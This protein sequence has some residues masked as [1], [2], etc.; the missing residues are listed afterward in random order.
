MAS[1]LYGP[2]NPKTLIPPIIPPPLADFETWRASSTTMHPNINTPNPIVYTQSSGY[3]VLIKEPPRPPPQPDDIGTL[4]PELISNISPYYVQALAGPNS[5]VVTMPASVN[6]N[7]GISSTTQRGFITA[8]GSKG[9][10]Y[11]L[12]VESPFAPTITT[13]IENPALAEG[14]EIRQQL[15][16]GGRDPR[17]YGF[18]PTDRIFINPDTGVPSYFYGDID[19]ARGQTYIGRTN[20][21][22]TLEN[23]STNDAQVFAQD[24]FIQ[25]SNAQRTDL[26]I[27]QMRK[28]NSEL[29][30]RKVAPISP[31]R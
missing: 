18:G 1:Q 27:S 3:D 30:Q 8:Y 29:W 19:R 26:Q 24:K 14:G 5:W 25:D 16:F 10:D 4:A 13:P 11:Q 9:G 23:A 20:L 2:P 12:A 31:G 6:S 7:L 21:N 28:T 15:L 22:M 17:A